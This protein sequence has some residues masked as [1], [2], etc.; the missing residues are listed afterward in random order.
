MNLLKIGVKILD[1]QNPKAKKLF[2]CKQCKS[3]VRK[4][5]VLFA[6]DG[7]C[8][9]LDCKRPELSKA[10]SFNIFQAA[11]APTVAQFLKMTL[12]AEEEIFNEYL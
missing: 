9:C 3:P 11:K 2:N 1:F 7:V 12:D 6:I 10:H 4:G 5:D 8:Y